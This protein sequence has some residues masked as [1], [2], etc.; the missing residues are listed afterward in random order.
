M[1][2]DCKA[3]GGFDEVDEDGLQSLVELLATSC[4]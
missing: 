2:F 3:V 1:G 4:N